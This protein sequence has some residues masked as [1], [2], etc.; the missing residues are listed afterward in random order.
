M[1]IKKRVTRSRLRFLTFDVVVERSS[2][3]NMKRRYIVCTNDD[4]HKKGN[5]DTLDT[6]LVRNTKIFLFLYLVE[7]LFFFFC[8]KGNGIRCNQVRRFSPRL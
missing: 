3:V 4:P 6:M 7:L 8:H 1:V 2:Q 5:A